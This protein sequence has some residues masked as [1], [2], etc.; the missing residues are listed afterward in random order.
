MPLVQLRFVETIEC[1]TGIFP[2]EAFRIR[3]RWI[4]VPIFLHFN[5]FS[6]SFSVTFLSDSIA[7][8]INMLILSCF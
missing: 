7:M 5:F 3:I 4:T 1:F 8:S 6:A 2:D